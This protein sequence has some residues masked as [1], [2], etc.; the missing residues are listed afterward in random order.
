MKIGKYNLSAIETGYFALDGGA[1]FGVIP[2]TIWEKTN[3]ADLRNRVKL[4]ARCLMLSGEK[5]NILID[6]GCGSKWDEK[7]RYIYDFNFELFNLEKCLIDSKIKPDDITDVILTHLHFDHTGGS[8]KYY[9]GKLVPAFP[10]ANYYVQKTNFEWAKNPC[11]K[12]RASFIKENY[13]PLYENGILKFID[14]DFNFDEELEIINLNGHT[15]GQQLV[16]ISDSSQTLLFNGDLFPYTAHIHIPSLP[17][18]DLQPLIT[19]EEKKKILN[20]AVEE[21][22]KLFF[23]HDPDTVIATVKNTEKGFTVKEKFITL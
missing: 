23:E 13:T 14:G 3:P 9:N 11:E 5:R 22:W 8:T 18:Y 1:M 16:K 20:R 17:G 6:T 15:F 7:A 12:D 4:T 10:N 21:E 2:K 19:M